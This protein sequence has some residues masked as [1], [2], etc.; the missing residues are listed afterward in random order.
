MLTKV[1]FKL[2]GSADPVRVKSRGLALLNDPWLNKGT[3]FTAEER[4][5]LGLSGLLPPHSADMEEQVM[6][7]MENY[8]HLSDPLD[9]NT[10]LISKSHRNVTHFYSVIMENLLQ[11][12]PLMYTPTDGYASQKF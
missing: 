12:T 3:S 11:M 6:R 1:E 10:F 4:I 5:A 7:V 2:P 9:K 8:A